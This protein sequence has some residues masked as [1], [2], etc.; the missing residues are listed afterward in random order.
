MPNCFIHKHLGNWLLTM[1]NKCPLSSHRIFSSAR[2]S[3]N[4]ARVCLYTLEISLFWCWVE[5]RADRCTPCLV[6]FTTNACEI[7]FEW[8]QVGWNMKRQVCTVSVDVHFIVV[9]LA[10]IES[11]HFGTGSNVNW[12]KDMLIVRKITT[13]KKP[14]ASLINHL[15]QYYH[16]VSNFAWRSTSNIPLLSIKINVLLND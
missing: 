7:I 13:Q 5:M 16:Q 9:A 11:D 1:R 6:L 14:N 12:Y 8:K 2:T 4:A 15:I 10:G 3:V